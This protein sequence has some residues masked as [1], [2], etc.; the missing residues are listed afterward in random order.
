MKKIYQIIVCFICLGSTVSKAGDFNLAIGNFDYSDKSKNASMLDLTYG[1]SEN[2]T[3][4]FLGEVVPVFGAFVTADSAAM[5]YAGAKI[6]Y[7]FGSFVLTPSFT[8]GIYS[9][10]D[11]KDLGHAIEFK[12]QINLGFDLG[13]DTNISAGYSHVSNA[14]LGD[15]NPGANSYSINFLTRF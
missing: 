11:G 6:D 15:K 7:K 2:K 13:P 10:G 5:L 14:S 8:P 12:S 4:T 3:S 1:F 9:K